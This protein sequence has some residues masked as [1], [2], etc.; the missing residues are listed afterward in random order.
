MAN[1]TLPSLP[2]EKR[3]TESSGNGEAAAQPTEGDAV[4]GTGRDEEKGSL[5][6]QEDGGPL[7]RKATDVPPDGGYGWVC[8]ACVFWINACTWGINSSYG[9]FLQNYLNNDYFP[10]AT[11]LDYA[12]I[13]GLSIAMALL[14]APLSTYLD[15]RYG[16]R[17][18]LAVGTVLEAGSLIGASFATRIWQLFL[19]QGVCFGW[20]MG[21]LFVGSAGVPAQ[22]FLRRR[23]LANGLATAGAGMG[24]LMWSLA[25]QAMIDSVGLGWNLRILGIMAFAVNGTATFLIR[26]RSKHIGSRP[27]VFDTQILRRPEFHL[28]AL[29]G[30]FLMIGYTSLLFSL[31]SY[32][33]SVGCSASQ[34]SLIGALQN[35]SL[36][37]SRPVIG[38]FSDRIGR[39]NVAATLSLLCSLF[40]FVIWIFAKSFGVLVFFALLVGVT[41]G[42]FTATVAPVAAEVV[43]LK[44]LGSALNLIWMYVTLPCLVAEVIALELRDKT[45]D[46]YLKTQCFTGVMY[47]VGAACLIGVRGWRVGVVRAKERIED[48]GGSE[49]DGKSPW[50]GWLRK[51]VSP[52]KV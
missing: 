5:K 35:L 13:G 1:E 40:C 51:V 23:S 6:Q 50:S 34:G 41:S 24:G 48:E 14:V 31:P 32:A 37:L 33:I 44:D 38:H 30:F 8:V 7:E 28:L 18:V 47:F 49:D 25:N 22:W 46:Q 19:S 21:F 26:D 10:G 3:K 27:R 45:G 11:S 29:W 15:R 4:V 17:P 9:V 43:G 12:F 39:L 42:T 2:M 36:G 20:G 52:K 16:T